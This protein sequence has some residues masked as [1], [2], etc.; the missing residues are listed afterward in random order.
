M[1]LTLRGSLR[2]SRILEEGE[3][4]GLNPVKLVKGEGLEGEGEAFSDLE[5]G[6]PGLL[7]LDAGLRD[8]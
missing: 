6:L 7:D 3:G 4:I 5:L 2:D 8:A 1:L